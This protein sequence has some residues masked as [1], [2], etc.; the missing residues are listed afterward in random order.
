MESSPKDKSGAKPSK[1]EWNEKLEETAKELGE[2]SKA[3]KT[4]H[5]DVARYASNVHEGLMYTSIVLG[6]VA[7]I[8]T[9]IVTAE[10][11]SDQTPDTLAIIAMVFSFVSGIFVA[12][13][14]F[15]QFDELSLA[16]KQTAAKY[17]S[18]EGNVRRQL[19][20]YRCNRQ[21]AKRYLEWL[22]N[23]YDELYASAP[24]IPQGVQD[25]YAKK[26]QKHGLHI[27][28]AIEDIIAINTDYH[29]EKIRDVNNRDEIAIEMRGSDSSD[30][31]PKAAPAECAKVSPPN[32]KNPESLKTLKRTHKL[33]VHQELNKYNDGHMV[34]ELSRMMGLND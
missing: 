13:V 17:T 2:N 10:N 14:K 29:P 32:A 23:T 19:A 8:L 34:Y 18:L 12:I 31:D 24:L 25:N 15:G 9:G 4:M 28:D 26:A 27:P 16:S 22:T 33:N 21:D 30:D 1:V 7:G 6:P 20:L 11:A 3:Y 5:L